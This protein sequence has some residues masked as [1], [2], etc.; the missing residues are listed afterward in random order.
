VKNILTVDVEEH[1]Q[2]ELFRH[3]VSRDT[4]RERQS[5]LTMN[6]IRLLDILDQHQTLAT[7]FT[8]GWV[9]DRHP[10]LISMIR[11]RGHELASH[12]YWHES[13]KR[14]S[15]EQFRE[16]LQRSLEALNK[17]AEVEVIGYRAPTF[18]AELDREWI[19]EILLA[20]G[21]RYDSSIYPAHHDIYGD[22]TAPRFPYA[23]NTD[24]GAL[25]EIPPTTYKV[26]GRNIAVCGGGSLRLFPLWFTRRAI[27]AYNRAGFA[28]VV[29]LH[30]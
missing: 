7:F 12:G 14:M 24:N 26:F 23:I 16:D 28:S 4:W 18:S 17:A 27:K 3:T 19:W 6:L 5:R 20:N 29:Y 9:A 25:L 8:L 2:V 15:P 11:D 22:P 1:F 21:I 10:Q 13:I 30:P